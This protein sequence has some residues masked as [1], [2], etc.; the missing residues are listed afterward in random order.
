MNKYKTVIISLI[1]L[2]FVGAAGFFIYK[3]FSGARRQGEGNEVSGE[4]ENTNNLENRIG[5]LEQSEQNNSA[6]IGGESQTVPKEKIPDL[7]SPIE[8][9]TAFS[10]DMQKETTEKI[11][12][13][14]NSLK[15][16]Y[17]SLDEWLELGLLRKLIGDFHGA[18]DAW[19][20]AATIRPKDAVSRHNLGFIYWQNLQD[21]K[22]SEENYLK[23]IEN[24]SRDIGAY[25][26]LSNV[27]YFSL[28]DTARA[29]DILEKGLKDNPG[30]EEL[31]QAMRDINL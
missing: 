25:I 10:E 30:N 29:K 13:L 2:A 27:Y 6:V 20:F 11:N 16:D 19:E 31:K 21:Y 5:Q 1:I 15:K 9:K 18:R 3:D 26:D 22:K 8:I 7:D 14:S 4:A 28:K 12:A 24:N 17:D 23:A